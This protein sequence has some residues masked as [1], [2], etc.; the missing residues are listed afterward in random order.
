MTDRATERPAACTA[1]CSGQG[2][3]E[4]L[5]H[6]STPPLPTGAGQ[7]H[8]LW[9]SAISRRPSSAGEGHGAT[10]LLKCWALG[11]CLS[12]TGSG[13]NVLCV[14]ERLAARGASQALVQADT[15]QT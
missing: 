4:A 6:T 1:L 15:G 12:D 14:Q 5:G 10:P 7:A 8:S 13:E 3:R 9:L 2:T 11:D